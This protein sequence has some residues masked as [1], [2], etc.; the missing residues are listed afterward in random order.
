MSWFTL[1]SKNIWERSRG[2]PNSLKKIII[3]FITKKL[4]KYIKILTIK[5]STAEE[6]DKPELVEKIKHINRCI[7]NIGKSVY[8]KNVIEMLN[9]YYT[10]K[11]KSDV[12]ILQDTNRHKFAFENCLFDLDKKEFRP[13]EPTDYITITA[14]YDYIEHPAQVEYINTL[15]ESIASNEIEGG[16]GIS[17]LQYLKNILSS[18]LYGLNKRREF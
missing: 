2:A 16:T 11:H 14:G 10:D 7:L 4:D 3:D 17:D 6:K 9:T 15:L 12:L 1:N 18:I 8:I 5:K 13:M